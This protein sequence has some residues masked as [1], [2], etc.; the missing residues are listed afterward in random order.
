M[1]PVTVTS[2]KYFFFLLL[3]VNVIW[4][5]YS[6]SSFCGLKKITY[7]IS[8]YFHHEVKLVLS[9]EKQKGLFFFSFTLEHTSM[10]E[11]QLPSQVLL[12]FCSTKK[13]TFS[14][15]ENSFTLIFQCI[16]PCPRHQTAPHSSVTFRPKPCEFSRNFQVD[17][18]GVFFAS[19]R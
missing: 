5:E 3:H 6:I 14:F 17:G 2:L 7:I 15:V 1:F 9:K 19:P 18:E 11:N 10:Y 16:I 13:K 12:E 4:T 8:L